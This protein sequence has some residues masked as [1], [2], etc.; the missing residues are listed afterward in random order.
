MDMVMTRL[1]SL[2][3][4]LAL[5]LTV[6][7]AQAETNIKTGAK[8][9]LNFA[10]FT[11]TSADYQT[12][13]AFTIGGFLKFDIPDSPIAIQPEILYTQM[14]AKQN[15]N[16][17][18]LDYLQLPVILKY[19]II[20]SGSVQP[21]IFGGLYASM[22]LRAEQSQTTGGLFG[23]GRNLENETETVDYGAV[24][25][26]GI[27]IEVGRSIFTTDVRYN[28]GLNDVFT[29]N[30]GRNGVLAVTIG[31]SLPDTTRD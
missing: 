31:V 22:R 4:A 3:A 10:T 6:T 18:R 25:G 28:L 16:E 14:G 11:G 15:G 9:G 7:P 2:I 17:I 19:A 30:S 20:P 27:D 12:L 29:N 23:G 21:N 5:F 24:F 1:F 26:A 13:T 8:G